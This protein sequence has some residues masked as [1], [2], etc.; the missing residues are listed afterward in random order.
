VLGRQ[1]AILWVIQHK[2]MAVSS[3]IR[4]LPGEGDRVVLYATR[5]ASGN[6]NKTLGQI[7]GLGTVKGS[8]E[9]RAIDVSGVTY[10][11]SFELELNLVAEP[12]KG[13]PFAP[14][15]PELEFI[16]KKATWGGALRRPIVRI[17]D[18]DL[19]RLEGAFRTHMRRRS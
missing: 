14:L 9:H 2:R 11:T 10:P 8:P 6:P 3:R 15:V 4:T 12:R 17:T 1:D 5:G 7:I 18:S 19:R 13:L 16:T